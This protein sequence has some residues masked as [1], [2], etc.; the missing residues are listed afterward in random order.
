MPNLSC[1]TGQGSNDKHPEKVFIPKFP[2]FTPVIVTLV[3]LCGK[4]ISIDLKTHKGVL[5]N[6]TFSM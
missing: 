5:T 6:Q 3:N 1:V 2:Q 4:D